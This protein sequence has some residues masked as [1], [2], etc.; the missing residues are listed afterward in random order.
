VSAAKA[1]VVK[2]KSAAEPMA[3]VLSKA[4]FVIF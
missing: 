4:N 1:G 3:L 2:A